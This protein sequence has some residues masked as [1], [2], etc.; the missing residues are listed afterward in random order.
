MGS[1][2]LIPKSRE[3]QNRA[4]G[5][6]PSTLGHSSSTLRLEI[7]FHTTLTQATIV[8]ILDLPQFLQSL[9]SLV[10]STQ[11]HRPCPPH[12]AF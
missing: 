6:K 9:Q 2:Q 8:S 3:L 5:R 12:I 7:C 1:G 11:S 4:E 10:L